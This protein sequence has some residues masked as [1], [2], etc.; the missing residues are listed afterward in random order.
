M[1]DKDKF[2]ESEPGAMF[3]ELLDCGHVFEVKMLDRYMDEADVESGNDREDVEIKH[4]LCPIAT[5]SIPILYGRRYGNIIKKILAGFEAVKRRTFLSDVA[6]IVQ[7]QRIRKEVREIK[8]IQ[9]EV[10]EKIDQ[11]VTSGRLTSEEVN[12]C[13][14]QVTFLKF[15]GNLITKHKITKETSS[16][17]CC[18]INIITS[19]I[20]RRRDCFSEQE[21]KEF[22]EELSRT[23]L[24]VCFKGLMTALESK[25]VTLGP[26]DESSVDSIRS[27]LD[28]G[29]AL[30]K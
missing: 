2:S 29:E 14:N 7:I 28:S 22:Q 5:C 15:L 13:Q 16:E 23:E 27:A 19:R 9:K 4:K 8:G 1:C 12:S 10:L 24:L 20:M 3:V 17:L 11:S 30:G 6:S 21:L 26:E 18:K 25:S